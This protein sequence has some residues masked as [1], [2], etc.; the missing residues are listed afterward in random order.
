MIH[1]PK[2]ASSIF[3]FLAVFASILIIP[4]FSF[5]S[6]APIN[7]SA[8]GPTPL[9][10]YYSKIVKTMSQDKA[11][12]GGIVDYT[13]TITLGAAKN[14][15]TVEDIFSAGGRAPDTDFVLGSAKLDGNPISNP[16]LTA[17]NLNWIQY[18]FNLG[19]L[20][21]GNHT[22]TYQ[23]KINPNINCY[24]TPANEA[25]LDVAGING[26]L[27]TSTIRFGV[28]CSTPTPSPTPTP[29][30]ND[31]QCPNI[32]API[33]ASYAD[34]LHWIVGNPVLQEGSDKVYNLGANKYAQ[35]YCP[36]TGTN[37]IQTN[38]IPAGSFTQTQ[39]DSYVAN[40]YILVANGA[41]FGLD[42]QKYLAKNS[43]FTCTQ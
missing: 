42:S 25:H 32:N 40:G 29:T 2:T 39:I 18:V 22:L 35:C 16:T 33:Q 36:V 13:V 24:A 9:P 43:A 8:A 11:P 7:V 19:N 12:K 23:W 37:G 10:A 5:I 41:D 34:G 26:H 38:W 1:F 21:A 6:L 3:K 30:P 14:G 27:S 20:T 31:P 17:N 15:V 4:F 28:T